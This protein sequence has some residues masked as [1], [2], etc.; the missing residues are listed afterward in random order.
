MP[1]A[2]SFRIVAR[3]PGGGPARVGVLATPHG[4]VETP[5]FCPVGTRGTVRGL[6]PD[7]LR[8]TGSRMLLANAYHLALRPGAESVRA[9]G[10]LHRLMGWDGPILSDSGGYQVFSLA[11][12]PGADEGR[13]VAAPPRRPRARGAAPGVSA[14]IRVT[15]DGVRFRS[16]VDGSEMFLGPREAVALQEA[17]GADIAMVLDECV[18]AGAP[19]GAVAAAA[20]RTGRWARAA[21]AARTR[22]DQALFGI[23]EP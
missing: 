12:P 18:A 6:L 21:L 7:R 1:P 19:A 10:G 16:P 8:A 13:G 11:E 15:D 5:A 3:D 4:E 9:L 14:G 20:A 23:V 22:A 17:L 2:V